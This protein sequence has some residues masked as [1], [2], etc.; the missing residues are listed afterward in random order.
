[1]GIG[2]ASLGLGFSGESWTGMIGKWEKR[3]KKDEWDFFRFIC[4]SG[5]RDCMLP[6]GPVWFDMEI[7]SCPGWALKTLLGR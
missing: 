1:M 5:S 3:K 4:R 6:D 7:Q 2:S